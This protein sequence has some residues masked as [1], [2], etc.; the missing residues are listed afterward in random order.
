MNVQN[1]TRVAVVHVNASQRVTIEGGGSIHGSAA[2]AWKS[3]SVIDNRMS[4]YGDD[5][6]DSYRTHLLLVTSSHDVTVRGN[7]TAG[8]SYLKI[9]NSSDWTF[10]MD[11]SSNIH[12]DGVDIYG[13]RRFPNNDGFDPESCQNVT[14]TNSRID[15]ADDG[16]CPKANKGSGPLLGLWVYN[17][18]IRSHSHA[19]KFG[20]NTDELMKDIL[21]N[22]VTIWDSNGGMSIQQRSEGDIVNVTWSNIK[23]E[24]RYS[25]PRWWGNGEWLIVSNTPRGNGHAIG[26]IQGMRFV[27][28]TGRSENGGLLSGL[29]GGVSDVSFESID[30]KIETWSNY[31]TGPYPC[32]AD[33]LVCTNDTAHLCVKHPVPTGS[34]IQCMGSRDYRPVPAVVPCPHC[35]YTRTPSKANALYLENA[36]GVHFG[37]NVKFEFEQPRKDWFGRCL[38]KDNHTTGVTGSEGIVCIGES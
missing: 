27:N 35:Y 15:V 18:T 16:V 25:A 23:V 4:P 29:S 20:S 38:E 17:T 21:F 33:P 32:Y 2:Q 5:G 22:N 34:P 8:G 14:L 36:H 10:R 7:R 11:S 1:V 37:A 13:D 30:I 24:T 28:I 19:I 6:A 3:W 26:N 31:S 12:V 9:H